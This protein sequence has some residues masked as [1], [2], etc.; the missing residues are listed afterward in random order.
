VLEQGCAPEY[1]VRS[2]RSRRESERC[3]YC[4]AIAYRYESTDSQVLLCSGDSCI[5]YDTVDVADTRKLALKSSIVVKASWAIRLSAISFG[6]E[7]S[8]NEPIGVMLGC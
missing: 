6:T 4:L 8:A 2:L 5:M 1:R 3:L 7:L